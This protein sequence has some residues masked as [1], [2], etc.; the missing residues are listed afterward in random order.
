M[1]TLIMGVGWR[2]PVHG[3]AEG[4]KICPLDFCFFQL[5]R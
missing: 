1:I 2:K 4:I 5:I 3:N